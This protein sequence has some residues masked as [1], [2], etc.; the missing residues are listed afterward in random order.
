MFEMINCSVCKCGRECDVLGHG[1]GTRLCVLFW[2]YFV[3][4]F[5]LSVSWA[6]VAGNVVCLTRVEESCGSVKI[7]ELEKVWLVDF[8]ELIKKGVGNREG[9]ARV[10][11][12]FSG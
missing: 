9:L 5:V 12:N 3:C 11:S 2:L 7:G 6:S 8:A 10:A 1:H 4:L